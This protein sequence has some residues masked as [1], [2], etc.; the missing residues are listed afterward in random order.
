MVPNNNGTYSIELLLRL[1]NIMHVKQC[2]GVACMGIFNYLFI[3][4]REGVDLF[5]K[6]VPRSSCCGGAG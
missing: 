1:D 5:L 3:W 6:W 4:L 2:G